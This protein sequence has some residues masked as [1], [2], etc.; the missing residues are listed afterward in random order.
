MTA[1]PAGR[2]WFSLPAF[3]VLI[4]YEKILRKLDRIIR[5]DRFF[6]LPVAQVEVLLD[7]AALVA[8]LLGF[9]WLIVRLAER[10]VRV[11]NG[12][13]DDFQRFYHNRIMFCTLA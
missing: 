8:V 5:S 11:T 9:L 7:L 3:R 4:P 13:G 2:Q 10:M 6:R 12:L 1:N